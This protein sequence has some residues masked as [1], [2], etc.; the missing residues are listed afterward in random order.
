M[1][2]EKRRKLS[3]IFNLLYRGEI[4]EKR[5]SGC[6]SRITLDPRTSVGQRT[7][8]NC[9]KQ[10]AFFDSAAAIVDRNSNRG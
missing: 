3:R 7:L 4:G 8:C 9:L 5:D 1:Q 10:K 6:F 2:L